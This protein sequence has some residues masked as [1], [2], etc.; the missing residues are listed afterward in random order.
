MTDPWCRLAD[1][2]KR[3]EVPD[4][5][6]SRLDQVFAI[7]PETYSERAWVGTRW[8]VGQA[9]V[10]HVFGGEDQQFRVV[11]RAPDAEVMAFEHLGP[12]YFRADWG[13]NVVGVILDGDTDWDEVAELLTESYCVQAPARL[14]RMIAT[15]AGSVNGEESR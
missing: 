11:F 1:V 9:T 13:R 14:T 2:A 12:R 4:E 6:I 3:P 15:E 5:W 8:R 10:A 7:F